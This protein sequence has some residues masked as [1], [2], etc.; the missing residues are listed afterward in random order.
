MQAFTLF[1]VYFIFW[2][3]TLFMVLPFGVQSQAEADTI[4]PGTDPG[5]PVNGRMGV[6]LLANTAVSA[7]LFGIWY[8]V[9]QI[10]GYG[11][12]DLAALFPK[13]PGS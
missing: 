12:S 13:P 2:W 10:L 4:V 9:T 7:V 8:Y 5:A 1:A 3:V 11:L 6:K